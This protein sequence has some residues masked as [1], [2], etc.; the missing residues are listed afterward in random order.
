MAVHFLAKARNSYFWLGRYDKRE[1]L[2]EKLKTQQHEVSEEAFT[3]SLRESARGAVSGGH[4]SLLQALEHPFTNG[5]LDYDAC[6]VHHEPDRCLD[7]DFDYTRLAH[8]ALER[9]Y[10]DV[11]QYI[12]EHQ[13]R[14]HHPTNC[15]LAFDC[16]SVMFH[17]FD[18]R[19]YDALKSFGTIC[20]HEETRRK[21]TD[22][23]W[24]LE[25]RYDVRQV[26]LY[27]LYVNETSVAIRYQEMELMKLEWSRLLQIANEFWNGLKQTMMSTPTTTAMAVA[28]FEDGN[29]REEEKK[30]DLVLSFDFKS[31]DNTN[32]KKKKKTKK[33]KKKNRGGRGKNIQITKKY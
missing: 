8:I 13:T 4:L 21:I 24:D 5:D 9:N 29:V 28:L 26:L 32:N 19:N 12:V 30:D 6:Y 11:L 1:W 25:P 2:F 17:A 14:R 10:M 33:G 20:I 3:H 15:P 16:C 27:C 22:M 31:N 23:C 7:I 18:L